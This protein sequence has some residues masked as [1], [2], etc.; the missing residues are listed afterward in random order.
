MPTA[1]ARRRRAAHLPA[2]PAARMTIWVLGVYGI[3][4]GLLIIMSRPDR[5][6]GP[7]FT[8]LNDLPGAPDS[9]GWSVMLFGLLILVGSATHRWRLKGLGLILLSS[10]S[11]VFAAGLFYATTVQPTAPTTGGP[12]YT[13]LG[14]WTALLTLVDEGPRDGPTQL[15]R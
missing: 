3:V 15:P 14:V 5:W 9:W 10:W 7:S 4:Q 8:T 6:R 1:K 11:F 2:S 12:T 13:L